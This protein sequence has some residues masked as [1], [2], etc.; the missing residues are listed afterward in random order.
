MKN[1]AVFLDRDGVINKDYGYVHQVEKFEIYPQVFPAL[2]KLQEAGFKLFVVTNQSGI[3]VGYYTE[4]DFHNVN[5]HMLSVFKKEG[6]KIEKVYYCPHHPEGV[7]PELTKKC[8][9]RKPESGM[10]KQAI[11]EFNIDPKQSFLIGDK[12]TDIQ[13]AHKEGIKAILVKTGQ[14]L[15]HVDNTTADYIAEDILD[16]VENFILKKAT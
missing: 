2:K 12:E 16:A 14:G 3:A 13:A 8:E 7:V 6:I 4:E 1:K 10:I 9:C 15:K 11:K 5:N